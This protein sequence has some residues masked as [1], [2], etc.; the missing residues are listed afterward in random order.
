MASI[1]FALLASLAER[2]FAQAQAHNYKPQSCVNAPKCLP[3]LRFMS[4]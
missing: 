4:F 1:V 2:E 3:C